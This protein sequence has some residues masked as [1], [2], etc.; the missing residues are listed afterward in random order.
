LDLAGRNEHEKALKLYFLRHGDAD[1][2]GWQRPDE[3]RPLTPEGKEKMRRTAKFLADRGI[4]PQVILSSPLP[5]AL[6]TAE[7]MAAALRMEV[8][9]DPRLGPGFGHEALAQIIS[10]RAPEDIMLVGHEPGFSLAVWDLTGG[11]VKMAK[12]GL[13]RVDLE[14]PSDLR[15]HVALLIPP[16]ISSR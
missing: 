1:W 9:I 16:R 6:Q 2:P 11:R 7:L 3:E 12:G 5:R 4:S 14:D 10:E 15:G 8:V 13:A